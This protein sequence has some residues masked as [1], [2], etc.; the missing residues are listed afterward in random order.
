MPIN[1]IIGSTT[2]DLKAK[3]AKVAKNKTQ[4]SEK[5]VTG[6][7]KDKPAKPGTR[8]TQAFSVKA[9]PDVLSD[10]DMVVGVSNGNLH[11]FENIGTKT[12]ASFT[13]AVNL[14]ANGT[15]IECVAKS[16]PTFEEY[17]ICVGKIWATE[18]DGRPLVAV[19]IG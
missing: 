3:A 6:T 12:S 17:Q 1:P 7:W 15:D 2:S 18:S 10:F 5:P 8:F 9:D 4:I 13:T 11:Y 14:Q 19:K 16:S